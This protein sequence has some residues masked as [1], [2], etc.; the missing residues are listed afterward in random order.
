M[1]D[2]QERLVAW[3]EGV[4]LSQQEAASVLGISVRS[5]SRYET[6]REPQKRIARQ[7][8]ER[9]AEHRPAPEL[10]RQTPDTG[11][12]PETPPE[13]T[14]Y[15]VLRVE[16]ADGRIILRCLFRIEAEAPDVTRL[17]TPGE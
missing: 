2:L 6:G 14:E 8:Q 5:L 17:T 15:E 9:M 4:G 11:R 13:R 7:L 3:R 12:V 16:S 1:P 10:S